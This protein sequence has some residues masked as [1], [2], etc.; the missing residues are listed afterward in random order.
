MSGAASG[1]GVD[2]ECVKAYLDVKRK[3]AHK[4]VLFAIGAPCA[5]LQTQR[6]RRARTCATRLLQQA[7]CGVRG[8]M[9]ARGC[10]ARCGGAPAPR[11]TRARRARRRERQENRHPA[12]EHAQRAS[13][14]LQ[15]HARGPF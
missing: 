4:F 6:Q 2:E 13:Q 11:V 14:L 9:R 5:A 10:C 8:R 3:R 15:R 7:E 12:Q 1:V